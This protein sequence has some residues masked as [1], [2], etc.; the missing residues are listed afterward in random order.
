MKVRERL[1]KILA[2]AT[3]QPLKRIEENTDR[4]YFMSAEDAQAYGLIDD[5]IR[6]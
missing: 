6:P 1:N 4:D 3:G 2:E 5:I